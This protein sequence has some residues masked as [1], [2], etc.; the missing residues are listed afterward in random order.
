MP[1]HKKHFD[2]ARPGSVS[3]QHTS[4]PIITGQDQ[5]TQ[6]PMMKFPTEVQPKQTTSEAKTK[7]LLAH[8][9]PDILPINP[10]VVEKP[11]QEHLITSFGGEVEPVNEPA[12][13]NISQATQKQVN[14]DTVNQLIQSRSYK[15]P[16]KHKKSN[17]STLIIVVL[18]ITILVIAGLYLLSVYTNVL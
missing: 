7:R 15:L 10:V 3:P 11:S 14:N 12:G 16:I 2:I 17:A 4:R 9:E 13:A 6:D 5:I 8:E 1:D 18:L